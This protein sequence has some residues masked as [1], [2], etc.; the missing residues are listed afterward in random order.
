VASTANLDLVTI[1]GEPGLTSLFVTGNVYASNALTTPSVITTTANVG[2]LNV[3][4][5]Q[6]TSLVPATTAIFMNLQSSYQLNSTG[7][8]TGNV[9]G[10]ITP[11]LYT[12]FGP[13]PSATWNRIGNNPIISGPSSTGS[14]RFSQV[15]V[16][17]F[18]AVIAVDS[19][20][21]TIAISS[22]AADIHSNLAD[23]GVWQYCYKYNIGQ[24]P[25]VI[26]SLPINVTDSSKYYF[27]DIET[28]NQTD[29]I[30][31]TAYS[32]TSGGFNTGTYVIVRPI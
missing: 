6:T 31:Q 30:R 10:T 25:Q 2:T 16:Y 15:G 29:Y 3:T 19:G 14:F 1:T 17:E 12:L 11:N 4:S 20:I 24:T 22:N 13:N 21:K 9:S 18:R 32:N 5:I 28:L 7:N 26:A 8:W 23:T 27:V